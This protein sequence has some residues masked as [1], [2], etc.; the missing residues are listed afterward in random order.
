MRKESGIGYT[1]VSGL[2]FGLGMLFMGNSR[3]SKGFR[4]FL[5]NALPHQPR[6]YGLTIT[7]EFKQYFAAEAACSGLTLVTDAATADDNVYYD[8][9]PTDYSTSGVPLSYKGYLVGK[10][11]PGD[12]RFFG[13]TQREAIQQMCDIVKGQGGKVSD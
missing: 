8:G 7:P 13:S 11:I 9:I 2:I 10:T 5:H 6:I 3:E 1:L 4:N 12:G